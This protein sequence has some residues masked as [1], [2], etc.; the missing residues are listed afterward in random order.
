MLG[1][2]GHLGGP[3]IASGYQPNALPTQLFSFLGGNVATYLM[4]LAGFLLLVF[5][6]S[7]PNGMSA[8][9][10]RQ[11]ARWLAFLRRRVPTR[12]RATIVTSARSHGCSW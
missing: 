12:S 11:N 6:P 8:E 4:I 7:L 1:G 3:L 5:L 2:V 10:E 9:T